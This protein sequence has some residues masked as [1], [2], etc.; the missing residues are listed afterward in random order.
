MVLLHL[1]IDSSLIVQI[2]RLLRVQTNGLI[3][4]GDGLLEF[5]LFVG[6]VS[7]VFSNDVSCFLLLFLLLRLW[8]LWLGRR[9]SICLLLSRCLLGHISSH[10]L[11]HI[12]QVEV[13]WSV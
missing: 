8:F 9:G 2:K 13:T 1:D 7:F 12:V 11:H 5:L 4:V 6:L 10:I 3:V